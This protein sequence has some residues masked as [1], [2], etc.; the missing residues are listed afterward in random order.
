[1][2]DGLRRSNPGVFEERPVD[3]A[4]WAVA[5]LVQTQLGDALILIGGAEKT[6]QAG[7]TAAVSRK[8]LACI[9]SFGGA[10]ARLNER[11]AASPTVRAASDRAI[12]AIA[13]TL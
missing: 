11:F 1:M 9:G 3:A 13:G 10:A 12:T 2:F 7:L 6:E 5:K 4:S 8:P